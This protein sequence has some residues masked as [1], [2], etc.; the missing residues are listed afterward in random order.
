MTKPTEAEAALDAAA[1]A[2]TQPLT[3]QPTVNSRAEFDAL[4]AK[5]TGP[6][7]VDFV[8]EGCGHCV[9]EA[10][11]FDKLMSECGS[12]AT[13]ARV[14]ITQDWASQLADQLKVDGTPTALLADSAAL[15][16]AGKGR[17][18]TDLDSS[19]VRRKIKCAR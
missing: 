3:L 4:L 5:A 13:L 18:V 6:V 10:P 14:E 17:E 9:D 11:K 19:A 16:L 7:L 12:K 8:Q 2:D 15:F 1:D